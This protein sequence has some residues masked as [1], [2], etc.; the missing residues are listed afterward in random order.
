MGTVNYNCPSCAAPLTF[1]PERQRF[2]CDYCLS[3]FS[4]EKIQQLYAKREEG[5]A[6]A[7]QEF[8]EEQHEGYVFHCDSCGAEVVTT[9]STAATTCFYCHNPVVMKGRLSGDFRPDRIIPFR[10]SKEQAVSVFMENTKKKK[11]L[12]K[13][14]LSNNHIE[15][16]TGVY[17]PYWY[18]DTQQDSHMVATGKKYRHWTSGNRRYTE[19]SYFN[20]YRSGDVYVR[21]VFERALSSTD[22][23]MLQCV[24][25]F[26]L[27]QAQKF[28]MSYLS[29]FQAEKRD[30]EKRNIQQMVD[31][32]VDEYCKQV[33]KGTC[34]GYSDVQIKSYNDRTDIESWSYT[35]LPVW[36]MTY[37]YKG[38]IYPYAINGQTGK[39]YGSLPAATGRL[40]ALAGIIA[41]AAFVLGL[42]GGML[43]IC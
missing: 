32:R 27:S 38:K 19:T 7:R 6:D 5:G 28:S 37:K 13:D 12:P 4:P 3:E 42:L 2:C 31:S 18:I 33:L 1:N 25:P 22:R 23:E 35:L 11:F 41:G 20:L 10:L 39:I 14:F 40:V 17:F 29:G 36:I 30:I 24:H 34:K 43:F 9:S 16:M 15:K 21:N 26:D 8:K